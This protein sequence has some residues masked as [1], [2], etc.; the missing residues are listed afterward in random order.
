VSGFAAVQL[1]VLRI[2]WLTDWSQSLNVLDWIGRLSLLTVPASMAIGVA[3]IRRD[4]G[5]VGDLVVELG[6]AKPGEVRDALARSVGDPS[7]E[8]GLWIPAERRYVDER[9]VTV[10]GLANADSRALPTQ[11]RFK[12]SPAD[13]IPRRPG[14]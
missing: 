5:L 7:L 14:S 13:S 9:G 6:A 4:R 1:I 3:T 2:A 11:P 8:L 12:P 10:T